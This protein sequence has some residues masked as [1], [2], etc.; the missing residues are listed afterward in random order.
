LSY[1]GDV[2]Q[3]QGDDEAARKCYEEALAIATR[4]FQLDP[5]NECR[6]RDVVLAERLLADMKKNAEVV[7]KTRNALAT[8]RKLHDIVGQQVQQDRANAMWRSH[9]VEHNANIARC[10][11]VLAS[12]KQGK[13]QNLDQARALLR[14]GFAI[15]AN[16]CKRYP[17]PRLFVSGFND[18]CWGHALVLQ[19]EQKMP[20]AWAFVVKG[21]QALVDFFKRRAQQEPDNLAW[22]EQL[23]QWYLKLA[24]AL[25]KDKNEAAAVAARREAVKTYERLVG[26]QPQYSKWRRCLAEARAG[27]K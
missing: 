11:A 23:A 14:E 3:A 17:N 20:Q 19:A 26:L 12:K 5:E 21:R 22:Q 1:E 24:P 27:L 2:N 6:K 9:L 10:L 16:L 18:L 4:A 15:N 13:P 7:E 25:S 8:C